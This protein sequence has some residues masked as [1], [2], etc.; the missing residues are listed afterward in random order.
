M[1]SQILTKFLQKT[2]QESIKL[3]M[4]LL[5]SFLQINHHF[6]NHAQVLTSQIQ[7]TLSGIDIN[8]FRAVNSNCFIA[9]MS[10][11]S[12]YMATVSQLKSFGQLD[13]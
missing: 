7:L 3:M 1:I 13:I 12:S 2:L 6:S 11:I 5:P 4:A 8:C 9:G 10:N